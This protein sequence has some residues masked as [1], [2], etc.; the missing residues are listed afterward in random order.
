MNTMIKTLVAAAGLAAAC[1]FVNAA[2]AGG[3]PAGRPAVTAPAAAHSRHHALVREHRRFEHRVVKH[4]G[5]NPQQVAQIKTIRGNTHDTVKSIRANTG[6]TPAQKK[7][8]IRAIVKSA[9]TQERAVLT[10]GQQAKLDH[11]RA[12]MRARLGWL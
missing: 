8:Q 10:P 3:V 5:L 4:L 9:R 6:L 12:R 2:T 1:P 7:A 11:L